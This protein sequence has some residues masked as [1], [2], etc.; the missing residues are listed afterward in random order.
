MQIHSVVVF[1]SLL[2]SLTIA[3]AAFIA[4]VAIVLLGVW[5]LSPNNMGL[6]HRRLIGNYA[7]RGVWLILVT[8]IILKLLT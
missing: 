2:S 1:F 6:A 3:H 4:I 5:R 8:A 7:V